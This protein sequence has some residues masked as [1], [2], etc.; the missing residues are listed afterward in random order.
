MAA[1]RE[2]KSLKDLV[3]YQ[4]CNPFSGH[5]E[6]VVQLM[7]QKHGHAEQLPVIQLCLGIEWE[8]M[9]IHLS[10]ADSCFQILEIAKSL[11]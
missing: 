8:S 6:S 9:P 5:I 7:D 2:G 10:F 11:Y 1:G 3:D 4:A